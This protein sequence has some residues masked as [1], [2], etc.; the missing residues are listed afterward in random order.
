MSSFM[1]TAVRKTFVG[2]LL[3]LAATVLPMAAQT[4]TSAVNTV[5]FDLFPNPKFVACLGIP[6]GPTPKASVTVT[7]GTLNDTLVINASNIRPGIAFDMFTVERSNLLSDHT[8]D[9]NFK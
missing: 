8:V 2:A 3:A 4:S 6:G 5:R 7:R 1:H 9:P